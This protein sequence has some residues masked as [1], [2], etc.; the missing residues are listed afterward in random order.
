M[1]GA[2]ILAHGSREKKTEDTFHAIV[3]MATKDVE[4]PVE[5]AFMEFGRPNISG[6]LN[7][8]IEKGVTNIKVVPY[9][10]FSGIHIREDIP[11]EIDEFLKEH[12]GVTITLGQTLGEDPR[13][14]QVLADR[15][16]G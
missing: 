15:I 9:F 2:L 11:Q 14:A 6:G 10:L 12:K 7:K 8:L 16:T 3:K 5:T 13:I 4:I 1:N